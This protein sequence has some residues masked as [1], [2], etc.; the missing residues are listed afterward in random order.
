M[1][2]GGMGLDVRELRG[3]CGLGVGGIGGGVRVGV[4]FAAIE[5]ILSIRK[6]LLQDMVGTFRA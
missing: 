3:R 4:S 2:R 5:F 6:N 1:A